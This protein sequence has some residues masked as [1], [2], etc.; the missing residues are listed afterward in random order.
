MSSIQSELTRLSL[1]KPTEAPLKDY[2]YNNEQLAPDRAT[3][4]RLELERALVEEVSKN[5]RKKLLRKLGVRVD[6]KGDKEAE[7]ILNKSLDNKDIVNKRA[8][9]GVSYSLD[10]PKEAPI[11]Y[12]RVATKTQT[13][14]RFAFN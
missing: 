14:K 3:L 6:A 10:A 7:M 11:K 4:E 1:V 2:V 9:F 5:K 8:K 12:Y 13:T